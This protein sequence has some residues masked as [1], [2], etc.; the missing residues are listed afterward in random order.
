[1]PVKPNRTLLASVL[2]LLAFCSARAGSTLSDG[3]RRWLNQEVLY[4]ISTQ[5][6]KD[7]LEL[8]SEEERERFIR[9]FWEIRDPDPATENNEFR[10]EHERRIRYANERFHDGQP[11][12]KSERGRIYIMHGPPDDVSYEFGGN[13]L[14]IQI[15]RP[16]ELLTGGIRDRRRLHPIDVVRPESEIWLYRHLPGARSFPGLFQVVFSRTDSGKLQQLQLSIRGA[17]RDGDASYAA[18]VSRD[19]SI[20]AF[21][22]G[23]KFGG[24]YEILY[25]GQYKFGNIDDLY[26]AVFYPGRPPSFTVTDLQRGLRDLERSPGD[27]MEEHLARKRK[28]REQVTSRI[29]F[30]RFDVNLSQAAVRQPNGRTLLAVT[31]G[32]PARFQGDELEL[33]L[34]LVSEDGQAVASA[35]DR[36]TLTSNTK[37]QSAD[38]REFL[39]R[40]RLVA[41]PGLY[42]LRAYG[43]LAKAKRAA[44]VERQVE[45]P[46][47]GKGEL[48]MSEVLLFDRVVPRS[49]GA[50]VPYSHLLG[51]SRPVLLRNFALLPASDDRFRRREK[52]TA[53]FE[54]YQPG[55]SAKDARPSL[56]LRC[57]LWN[58]KRL[59]GA[60]PATRLDYVTETK[61]AEDGFQQTTYGLSIPLQTL[62]P[63]EYWLELEVYDTLT[64]RSVGRRTRFWIE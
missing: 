48:G 52:L 50:Q 37:V 36:V 28:L 34:D 63:G 4:I 3:H 18:R 30:E 29:V 35:V 20:L 49:Q 47:F 2:L 24:E 54:I 5:E 41:L 39:Y 64:N 38:G 26:R 6:R 45:L 44:L 62:R 7:F 59:M 58:D 61:Q 33:L 23:Q 22:N 27:V 57:R 14:T 19:T 1:M 40:A 9:R 31:L 21:I 46:D 15:E 13:P 10:E 42:T 11:G 51:A 17:T 16:T 43:Q 8:E 25:A 32:V 55:L 12:W 56:D 53:L 60:I